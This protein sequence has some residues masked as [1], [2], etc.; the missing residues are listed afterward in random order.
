MTIKRILIASDPLFTKES[1]QHNNRRW[2]TDL[3]SRPIQLAT[4]TR[5]GELKSSIDGDAT[6]IDRE[7]FFKLSNID[8]DLTMTQFWYDVNSITQASLD[9]LSEFVDSS[10]LVVGYELSMQTRELLDKINV[11]FIDMWLHPVR[12]LDD[13]LFGM[14]SN[15]YEINSEIFKFHLDDDVAY[16]YA[17]KI[18]IQTYKG[19]RRIEADV[20]DNSALFIGQMLNDKSICKDGKMLSVLDFKEKFEDLGR[21]YS[22]VYYSKHP[23]LRSGDEEINRYISSLSFVELT[24]IPTYRLL[25]SNKIAKVTSLSSSVI[26]EAKYFGKDTEYFFKP[27]MTINDPMDE[28]TFASI[29]QEYISPHFWS[30]ILSP[31][32]DTKETKKIMFLDP[33]DKIRDMLGFYWGY[34]DVDKNE[35][36]RQQVQKNAK[37]KPHKT[38]KT[39]VQATSR[40]KVKQFSGFYQSKEDW[41]DLKNKIDQSSVVSFDIFDTLLERVIDQPNDIFD[42][43]SGEVHR[44]F[45]TIS[46]FKTERQKA[47]HYAVSR[48]MVNGEEVLLHDRYIAMGEELG[49]SRN[50]VDWMYEY[51]LS[52]ERQFCIQ[53]YWGMK[54]FNYAK[55]TGKKIILVSDIF[56]DRSFILELLNKNNITGYDKIYLSSEEGL[57]K[58]TGNLFNVVT[59]DLNKI[60]SNGVLH[61][62]D[63][64]RSDTENAAKH[65]FKTHFMPTKRAVT[66]KC[67][68]FLSIYD[69]IDDPLTKSAVSGLVSK[70]YTSNIIPKD[71]SFSQQSVDIFSYS[72]LGPMF[73]GFANW[74]LKITQNNQIKDIY[75]LARDGEIVK[76]V[77][78]TL[79]KHIPGAPRSHYIYASRRS[80]RV[81]S[82][83]NKE[84]ILTLLE[85]SFTAM[86]LNKLIEKRFGLQSYTFDR[87]DLETFGFKNDQ[88]IAD[89]KLNKENIIGLFSS[90][91]IIIDILRNA[92]KERISLLKYYESH[93]LS[94]NSD[95]NS[96]CFVDIGH[97][98]SIQ[99]SICQIL[100]LKNTL[101]LY[102]ATD[103]TANNTL[104]T[105]RF[106][107]YAA[108][109]L[110]AKSN[111]PYRNHILMYE[112]IF[113][114]SQG[115]F[116]KMEGDAPIFLSTKGEED[117]I[118]F[119]DKVH[120]YILNFSHD[121]IQYFGQFYSEFDISGENAIKTYDAFLNNPSQSDAKIF[122]NITFEISFSGRDY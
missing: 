65:G 111:H 30:S 83:K 89:W 10:T 93:G 56:F 118:E 113:L 69:E 11:P 22:K 41:N 80:V 110:P 55:E 59:S 61:M 102:F 67:S 117:R 37:T 112:M 81:A 45:P 115:S 122:E 26:T 103:A 14:N 53:R 101:G 92:E 5:P 38:N 77:Y 49:L 76:R 107:S 63:N 100:G 120:N 1:E 88:S 121:I 23:Y 62:G 31:I 43:M 32:M 9:Y 34:P 46:D 17:D 104:E 106:D 85:T 13:I 95:S 27:V 64:K 4:G 40:F 60:Q 48:N 75:F 16:L 51:E 29:Y 74:I 39:S 70:K 20:E 7:H 19:W 108:K 24:D 52:L 54:A 73:F 96:T 116:V 33:K 72:I 78:D 6:C 97:A 90:E 99:S 25:A 109:L 79:A 3:L 119:I 35:F 58:H 50:D 82:I 114:N 28:N 42:F 86:P 94:K 36:T 2:M 98:G 66:D 57:L 84:D 68:H 15:N 105:Q 18:K 71:A 87:N 12:F 8:V 91:G 44:R 47:R 21:K